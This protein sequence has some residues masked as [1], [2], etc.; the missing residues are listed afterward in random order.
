[1]LAGGFTTGVATGLGD[2]VLSAAVPAIRS[3]ASLASVSIR[4]AD[5]LVT[6]RIAV[7]N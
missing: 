2:M 1:M 4:E 6:T 7:K 3:R 5:P